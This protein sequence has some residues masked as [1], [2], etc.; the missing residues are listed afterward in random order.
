MIM[1][2]DMLK[3]FNVGS[4]LCLIVYSKVICFALSVV[5]VVIAMIIIG[6]NRLA[7]FF[8]K[9]L[10]YLSHYDIYYY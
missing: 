8:K 1:G 10:N 7:S 4:T 6:V 2:K 9:N 3:T 5:Y